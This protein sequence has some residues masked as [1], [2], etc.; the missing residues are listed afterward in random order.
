MS[1]SVS[2]LAQLE[3]SKL[4][5]IDSFQH[6]LPT[7]DVDPAGLKPGGD[8]GPYREASESAKKNSGI[9]IP[10]VWVRASEIG[11]GFDTCGRGRIK[12]HFSGPNVKFPR[13]EARM[14]QEESSFFLHSEEDVSRAS[15]LYL[16]HPVNE[17]LREYLC[18]VLKDSPTLQVKLTCYAQRYHK[19][20]ARSDFCWSLSV[21]G[22]PEIVFAILELKNARVIRP[23]EFIRARVK[24]DDLQTTLKEY[25]Q[26][27]KFSRFGS[28]I[29]E[30]GAIQKD[31]NNALKMVQ[32]ISKYALNEECKYVGLFDWFSMALF[33]YPKLSPKYV[34]EYME[35][36]FFAKES[37]GPDS[38]RVGLFGFLAEA[39]DKCLLE[40]LEPESE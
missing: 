8:H 22:R 33:R 3:V 38:F 25:A 32:Q 40:V 34:G 26:D 27:P 29:T 31:E 6:P 28:I 13:L 35:G 18:R 4:T 11:D 24:A 9:R 23:I 30:D 21:D 17:I 2:E 16:L 12:Q 37:G 14:P 7:F 20:S 1:L 39:L 36:S 19:S 5:I 15:V 10:K